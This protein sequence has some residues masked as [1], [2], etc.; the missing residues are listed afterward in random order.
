MMTA[1]VGRADCTG[2]VSGGIGGTRSTG[3]LAV[4]AAN[5]AA[6]TAES[7]PVTATTPETP[8]IVQDPTRR[9]ALSRSLGWYRGTSVVPAAAAATA[10]TVV[11]ARLRAGG[12]ACGRLRR[13]RAWCQGA[14]RRGSSAW[15]IGH[16]DRLMQLRRLRGRGIEAVRPKR[17]ARELRCD[18]VL[19]CHPEGGERADMAC[20]SDAGDDA[21]ERDQHP[22]RE[23]MRARLR[24]Q[25]GCPPD[26]ERRCGA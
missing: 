23:N 4:A 8:P 1:G 19:G 9:N 18:G 15:W 11:V 16:H 12:W 24:A 7:A 2:V 10:T 22:S 21:G 6:L 5:P 3:V 17:H 14:G 26:S 25:G 20:G 13:P